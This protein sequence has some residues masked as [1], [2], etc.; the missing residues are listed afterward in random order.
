MKD[1]EELSAELEFEKKNSIFELW[2]L[3]KDSIFN[4]LFVL[5]DSNDEDESPIDVFYEAGAD[6][7]QMF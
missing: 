6:Y 7:I 5:L 1:K 3:L 2:K 4:V